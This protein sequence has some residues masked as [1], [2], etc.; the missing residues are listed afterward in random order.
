MYIR[1][2]VC[3]CIRHFITNVHPRTTGRFLFFSFP[4]TFLRLGEERWPP[5][6]LPRNVK[7]FFFRLNNGP[8]A[9][10]GTRNVY[11]HGVGSTNNV[12]RGRAS[13]DSIGN[14]KTRD[15]MMIVS[16]IRCSC[17]TRTEPMGRD[18]RPLAFAAIVSGVV[19]SFATR[20]S[21]CSAVRGN[22]K[23][24][25]EE[26]KLK[27]KNPLHPENYTTSHGQLALLTR[28]R[29]CRSSSSTVCRSIS[30]LIT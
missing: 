5:P 28:R 6:I 21:T 24:T 20:L 22:G 29:R 18:Q 12:F 26:K 4:T 9:F 1:V 16:S 10:R 19:S 3:V 2:F 14:F 15:L 8:C 30:K 25:V 17:D 27:V 23:K 13:V 7:R 11:A